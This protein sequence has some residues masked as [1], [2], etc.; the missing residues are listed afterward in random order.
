ME[1]QAG[2]TEVHILSFGRLNY[3][4]SFQCLVILFL[5]EIPFHRNFCSWLALL[6]QSLSGFG[7]KVTWNVS[8]LLGEFVEGNASL[9]LVLSFAGILKT[10]DP[11]F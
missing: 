11:V 9:S 5:G 6:V 7:N 4:N 2:H 8:S 1:Y 10:S 3:P